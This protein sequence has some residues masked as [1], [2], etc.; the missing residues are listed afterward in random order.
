MVKW[1]MPARNAIKCYVENGYYHIYNRGINKSELFMD[2]QDYFVFMSYIQQYLTS[3]DER[4]LAQLLN[5]S[6][7]SS[8][9]RRRISRLLAL[10]NYSQDITL[11]AYCL[12]P[13]HFHF[14]IQ[15]KGLNCMNHF[16]SSLSLRY[17][18]YFNRKY[19]RSGPLFQGVYKAVLLTDEGHYLHLSR[20]IHKQA[21]ADSGSNQDFPSSYP[22]YLGLRETK[23]VHS[24][25][26]LELFSNS[27]PR[28]SYYTYVTEYNPIFDIAEPEI[29]N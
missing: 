1:G 14:F 9:E 5:N 19:K 17:A 3:K 26:I 4:I 23:W 6:T 12:M 2:S 18:M 16:M 13:N 20:Y 10:Q 24:E 7:I 8:V 11:L 27:N 21:L 22:E 25:E 28:L 29:D 15:Q